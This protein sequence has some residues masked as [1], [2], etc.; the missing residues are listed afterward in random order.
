MDEFNNNC[1]ICGTANAG[2]WVCDEC[3]TKKIGTHPM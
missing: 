2:R 3:A 1:F